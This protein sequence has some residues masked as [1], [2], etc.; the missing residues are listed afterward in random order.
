MRRIFILLF[1]ILLPC[2][3][4]CKGD[5]GVRRYKAEVVRAY[6]HETSAYTQGYDKR[7][8]RIYEPRDLKRGDLVFFNTNDSD[9]DLCDHTGIYLGNGYFIHASSSAKK[10]VVSQF[11]TSSSNYYERVFSWGLRILDT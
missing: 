5:G 6:P 1:C 8:T 3:V 2:S 4:S 11:K 9:S 10:V 7:F